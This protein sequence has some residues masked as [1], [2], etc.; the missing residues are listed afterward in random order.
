MSHYIVRSVG[1]VQDWPNPQF[2]SVVS[3][4]EARD[5]CVLFFTDEY[6]YSLAEMESLSKKDA[7]VMRTVS[8]RDGSKSYTAT[9]MFIGM[10]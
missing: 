8:V 5:H 1:R 2:L 4:F 10:F 7:A 9:V 6:R 3:E